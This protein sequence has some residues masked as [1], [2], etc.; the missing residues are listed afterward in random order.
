VSER[1]KIPYRV[2]LTL[3]ILSRVNHLKLF[4]FPTQKTKVAHAKRER[5]CRKRASE[6]AQKRE[7]AMARESERARTRKRAIARVVRVRE[8]EE[9]MRKG[10]RRK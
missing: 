3:L 7:R 4:L 1:E 2:L 5:V 8:S 6:R 10:A 9:T